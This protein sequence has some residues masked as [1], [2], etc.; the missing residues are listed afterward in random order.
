MHMLIPNYYNITI[1]KYSK[2][3]LLHC[4]NVFQGK[5]KNSIS[6]AVLFHLQTVVQIRPIFIRASPSTVK[7]A[8]KINYLTLVDNCPQSRIGK[9]RSI[10]CMPHVK[11]YIFSAQLLL[12][13]STLLRLV[14][15]IIVRQVSQSQETLG[16]K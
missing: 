9:T 2:L 12:A 1:K 6:P 4:W 3:F 16:E 13:I 8:S 10:Y 5:I 7:M 14:I 11:R 15:Q